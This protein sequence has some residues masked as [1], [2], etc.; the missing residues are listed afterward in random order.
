[1]TL[2]PGIAVICL[3]PSGLEVATTLARALPDGALHGL[4]RRLPDTEVG[5]E[6]T[7]EHVAELFAAGVP[8][9]GVCA[10]GILVRAVAPLLSAKHTEAPVLAVSEDGSSVV[11]LLGGHHGANALARQCADALGG[12][13]AVTTAGDVRFAAAL[14]A[15]PAG[16]RMSHPEAAREVM[17]AML[18]GEAV[19]LS[20]EVGDAA[21]LVESDLPFADGAP[22]I[23]RVTDRGVE[24][25]TFALHPPVLAL[26]VGC[27]RGCDPDELAVLVDEMLARE[28]LSRGAV[29]CV[30]SLDLKADETAMIALADSL[31]VPFVVFDAPRLEKET[32]RLATPSDIVFNEVGCHGVSEGAALAAAGADAELIV[33]KTKSTRATCAIARAASAIDAESAGLRPGHVTLVGLGPGEAALR[34]PAASRAI[35]DATDVVGY[36]YYL[37]LAGPLMRG[38]TRH[39]FPLGE[40]TERCRVALALAAEGRRVALLCSGDPG[41]YAMASLVFE[42]IDLEADPAWRGVGVDVVPGVSALQV[43]AA[44]AGAPIGHDFCAISLSDLLTP[45]EVVLQRVTAAAQG[46]FAIAFYNPVSHR[47]R[48]LLDEARTILLRHRPSDTPVMIGRLLGRYGESMGHTTLQDLRVD[49][50]D[51]MSVVLI[52]SSTTRRISHRGAPAVYTPR[53]YAK[54]RDS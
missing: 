36:G 38:K 40:E 29:A 51:M 52:G 26:G 49:D 11:P 48:D 8:I 37:D 50:V 4:S 24:D 25:N 32:P 43:A 45:R 3:G 44:R 31:D 22:T 12:H 9:I 53:G 16:W 27:E 13:A 42:V 39:D 2:P 46:D 23:V 10:A 14:D 15:P 18:A 35:T 21:W 6:D 20:V 1:M 54:K 17:A 30:A 7:M 28:G 33:P 34:T 5:F 19:G 47:R 41:V